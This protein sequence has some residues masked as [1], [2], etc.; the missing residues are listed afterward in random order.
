MQVADLLVSRACRA[1]TDQ[2]KNWQLK[3]QAA[4]LHVLSSATT[5]ATDG[6]QAMG[7]VG[8]MKDFGQEKRF[9]DAGQIQAFLGNFPMKKISFIKQIL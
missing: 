3:A 6:I 5:L 7:G 4:A 8:Y 1:M 2:E 9:R